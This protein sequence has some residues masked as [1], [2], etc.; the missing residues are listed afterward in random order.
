[1]PAFAKNAVPCAFG[2]FSRYQIADRGGIS[3][4]RLNE[5]FAGNG[6]VGFRVFKRVDGQLL[7]TNAI[8]TLK[9]KSA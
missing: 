8:K 3:V 6:L 7:D 1:M 5:L 2:D 9:I 4:M